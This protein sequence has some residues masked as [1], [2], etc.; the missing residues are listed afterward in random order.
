M[1]EKTMK[2]YLALVRISAK[3]HRKQN[4]MTRLCIV[5]AVFLVTVIFSM[6]DME[7][8]SQM[9]QAVQSDGKWHA[10]FLVDDEQAAL[11]AARPEVERTARYGVLN[12]HLEE[13]YQIE[14]IETGICSRL[15]KSWKGYSRKTR[16][17]WSSM[18][19]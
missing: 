3:H 7:M 10:G 19:R 8:R 1:K 13:G 5:L 9:V 14:G 15:R 18:N 12:Y 4:W 17:R 11:L 2:H 16:T 6:A